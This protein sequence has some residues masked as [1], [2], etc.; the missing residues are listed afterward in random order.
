MAQ[1]YQATN[2]TK[3]LQNLES[4][5][6]KAR[7]DATNRSSTRRK[8]STIVLLSLLLYFFAAIQFYLLN[9]HAPLLAALW[10]LLIPLAVYIPTAILIAYELQLIT[11][12]FL[13]NKKARNHNMVIKSLHS[14]LTLGICLFAFWSMIESYSLFA[15]ACGSSC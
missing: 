1:R 13:K 12:Y 6:I 11:L 10:W 3:K 4:T 14:L 8:Y 9:N 7:P 15:R 5:P 2:A